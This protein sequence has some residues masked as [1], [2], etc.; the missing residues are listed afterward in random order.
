MN[1]DDSVPTKFGGYFVRA[2]AVSLTVVLIASVVVLTGRIIN[3]LL[4]LDQLL[5][6]FKDAMLRV[7]DAFENTFNHLQHR[8][9]DEMAT[10]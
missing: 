6:S 2:F 4:L 5:G 3:S 9:P 8:N 1:H 10:A 7:R